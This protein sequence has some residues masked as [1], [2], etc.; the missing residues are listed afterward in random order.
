MPAQK[1]SWTAWPAPSPIRSAASSGAPLILVCLHIGREAHGITSRC[2]VASPTALRG[3]PLSR[4]SSFYDDIMR[5]YAA[6]E[7]ESGATTGWPALDKYYRVSAYPTEP[8]ILVVIH[9][10]SSWMVLCCRWFLAS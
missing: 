6:D 2:A 9:R 8:A 3:L 5:A 10:C 1:P 4:F 7:Q